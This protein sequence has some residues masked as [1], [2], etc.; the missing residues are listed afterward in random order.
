MSVPSAT[1]IRIMDLVICVGS[2]VVELLS[3][4]H[5]SIFMH[6]RPVSFASF[7]R[8][9]DILVLVSRS[10]GAYHLAGVH[11]QVLLM[12]MVVFLRRL[13]PTLLNVDGYIRSCARLH[14]FHL[15]FMH[16]YDGGICLG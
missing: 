3:Q 15:Q 16:F 12:V 2:Q 8:F 13:Q 6:D 9:V 1:A 10:V 11:V 4:L 7:S 14:P 5:T